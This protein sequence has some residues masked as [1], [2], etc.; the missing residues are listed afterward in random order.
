MKTCVKCGK[1]QPLEAFSRRAASGDGLHPYCRACVKVL[2]QARYRAD[3]ERYKAYARKWAAA[4]PELKAELTRRA[5][6]ERYKKDPAKVYAEARRWSKANPLKTAV[7]DAAKRARR[8]VRVV[9]WDAELDQLVREE[10]RDLTGKR[11]GATGVEWHVDHIVP[12]QARIACGLDNAFNL[13]VVPA[14]FNVV[15]QNRL[16]P[17][18]GFVVEARP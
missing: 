10:A 5:T 9:S 14:S 15:K 17:Q 6:R 12:L 2:H 13:A 1:T 3:P 4:N 11:R 18:R 7:Y 8:K 16:V